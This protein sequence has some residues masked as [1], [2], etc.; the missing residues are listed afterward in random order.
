MCSKEPL[1]D[2]FKTSYQ[3]R[4]GTLG[5]TTGM[6]SEKRSVRGMWH[7][8]SSQDCHCTVPLTSMTV[9]PFSSGLRRA[10]L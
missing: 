9:S 8:W 4:P 2:V 3:P 6:V 10:A 1:A 7:T 5:A